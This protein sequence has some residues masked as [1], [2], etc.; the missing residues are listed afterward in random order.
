MSNQEIPISHPRA[1]VYEHPKFILVETCSGYRSSWA[2]PEGKK[3][4]LSPDAQNSEIGDGLI[5]ALSASRVFTLENRPIIV[6]ETFAEWYEDWVA[7]VMRRYGFKTRRSLFKP[8]KSIGVNQYH[9]QVRLRPSWHERLECWSGFRGCEET[10]IH[11]P[12]PNDPEVI[13]QAV[14]LALSRCI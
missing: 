2:D 6:R 12:Y 4:Y 13:G 1:S 3:I 8:L 5:G 9:G 11:L 7:D 10:Y 14:R